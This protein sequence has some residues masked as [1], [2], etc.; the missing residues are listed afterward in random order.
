M[1]KLTEVIYVF[2]YSANMMVSVSMLV[3]VQGHS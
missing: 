3:T 2:A 1:F